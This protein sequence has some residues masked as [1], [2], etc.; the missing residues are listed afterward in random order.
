MLGC[1]EVDQSVTLRTSHNLF[2]RDIIIWYTDGLVYA[3]FTKML[4]HHGKSID[5]GEIP[6]EFPKLVMVVTEDWRL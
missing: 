4:S 6:T 2:I 3:P 1:L 5:L